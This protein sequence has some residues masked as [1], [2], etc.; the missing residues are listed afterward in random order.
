MASVKLKGVQWH[1]ENLEHT[2]LDDDYVRLTVC[3]YNIAILYYSYT[4][5]SHF[6][7]GLDPTL[8][9]NDPVHHWLG[10]I[11][12]IEYHVS[13]VENLQLTCVKFLPIY[14]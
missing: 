3:S 5:R 10:S 2:P 7:M 1:I 11:L 13:S 14:V 9:T 6:I 4:A 12:F 8:I